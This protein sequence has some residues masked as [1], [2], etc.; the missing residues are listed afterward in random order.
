MSSTYRTGPDPCGYP[1]KFRLNSLN[2]S[3]GHGDL[4]SH[5]QVLICLNRP[6]EDT[7]TDISYKDCPE[8]ITTKN[9]HGLAE[10]NTK[11][12]A[13]G[14]ISVYFNICVKY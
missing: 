9:R 4:T 5:R 11:F 14:K 3:Q 12:L 2:T 6:E 8:D 13:S 10:L 7:N 1:P